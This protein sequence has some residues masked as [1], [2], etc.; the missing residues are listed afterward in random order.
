MFGVS[1]R[2][3]YDQVRPRTTKDDHQGRPRTIK[4]D[5]V[6]PNNDK[7]RQIQQRTTILNK[8][9]KFGQV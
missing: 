8:V 4:Y 9:D 2:K 1:Q 5:Q 7:T 3:K 6:Q